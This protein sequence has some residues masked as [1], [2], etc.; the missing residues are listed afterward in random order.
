MKFD[1]ACMGELEK[2]AK[3][4]QAM[5]DI[6]LR[7]FFCEDMLAYEYHV[8]SSKEYLGVRLTLSLGGP[9]IFFDTYD[10][11]MSLYWGETHC[12]YRSIDDIINR[13]DETFEELY[14]MS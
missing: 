9:S 4:L 8:S 10:R 14:S 5:G 6:E 13:V 11:C 2:L 1:S 12:E 7:E 3:R